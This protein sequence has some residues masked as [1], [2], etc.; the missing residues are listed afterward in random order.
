[1]KC[2]TDVLNMCIGNTLEGQVLAVGT[3]H[4]P[5][6]AKGKGQAVLF[7]ATIRCCVHVGVPIRAQR[8]QFILG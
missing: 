3:T 6:A 8:K 1:M 7:T 5:F 2:D 4:S